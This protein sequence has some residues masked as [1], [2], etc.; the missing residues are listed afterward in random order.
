MASA[1]A[2]P[3]LPKPNPV[4]IREFFDWIDLDK[5]GVLSFP[6]FLRGTL[7]LLR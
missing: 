4:D 6:E 7:I 5:D 2:S 3:P 1:K